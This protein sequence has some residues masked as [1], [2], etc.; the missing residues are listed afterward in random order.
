MEECTDSSITSEHNGTT[1]FLW[2]VLWCFVALYVLDSVLAATALHN[3]SQA[4]DSLAA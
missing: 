1:L 2:V 4:H 3:V